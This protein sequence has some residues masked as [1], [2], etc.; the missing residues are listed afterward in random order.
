MI[1]VKVCRN[2]GSSDLVSDRSL[3][4]KMVCFK[5]GSSLFVDKPVNKLLNLKVFYFVI[6]VIVILII[7]I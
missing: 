4:G 1:K 2:C 5:C 6:A 7:I 3:G